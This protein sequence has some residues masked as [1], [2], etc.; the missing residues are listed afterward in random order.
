MLIPFAGHDL[1]EVRKRRFL[2]PQ[3]AL[4]M[5]RNGKDTLFIANHF[6]VTEATALRWIN[7][8]RAK[9]FQLSNPYSR[10]A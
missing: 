1:S 10:A 7:V 5:F 2:N 8:E 6:R 3:R 9:E 4:M